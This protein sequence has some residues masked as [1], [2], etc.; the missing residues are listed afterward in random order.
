MQ[1]TE[2]VIINDE[3]LRKWPL[4][5]PSDEGDKEERGRLL[6]IAGSAQMPGVAIIAGNAALRA[7]AG[8]VAIATA[9][10]IAP[11]VALAIP[12]SRVI[13]LEETPAGGIAP[14]AVSALEGLLA[15]LDAILLGPGMQDEPATCEFAAR[16]LPLLSSDIRLIIDAAAMGVVRGAQDGKGILG[17]SDLQALLTPHAGEMAHLTG[18][19][20]QEVAADPAAVATRMAAQW[21]AAVALKGAITHV[22]APDGRLWRHEGGSVGLAVSGSGDTLAGIIGGL[23]ARG[24]PLEQAAAWGVALH[25]RAGDR[26]AEQS[27]PL[28]YLAR[29]LSSQVPML[30]HALSVPG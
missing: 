20:K 18:I 25:A 30:M 1:Q 27:G 22:A 28:G 14:G 10:S 23:A 29:D 2:P 19:P 6:I 8:K 12:E 16:L 5:M 9:R 7:G 3:T 24:A 21:R 11:L 13:G 4:P 17:R 26:L 15:K